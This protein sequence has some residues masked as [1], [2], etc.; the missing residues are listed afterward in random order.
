MWLKIYVLVYMRSVKIFREMATIRDL[1]GPSSSCLANKRKARG[2]IE[3]R[4]V[5]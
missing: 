2:F 3:V 1:F 4:D 5:L